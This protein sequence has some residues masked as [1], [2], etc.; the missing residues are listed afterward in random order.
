MEVRG[1]SE[2]QREI[3]IDFFILIYLL[4]LNHLLRVLDSQS[5]IGCLYLKIFHF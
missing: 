1:G 5:G 2:T 4:F 3:V